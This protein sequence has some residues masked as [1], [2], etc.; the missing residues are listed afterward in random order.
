MSTT[1]AEFNFIKPDAS[2]NISPTPF[3]ENFDKVESLFK[4]IRV[5]YV[6]AQGQQ[7]LWEYRRWSSGNAECW[8]EEYTVSTMYLSNSWGGLYSGSIASPGKYPITFKK[9]PI[10]IPTFSN[11]STGTA[12]Y[13]FPIWAQPDGTTTTCP[14]FQGI[15]PTKGSIKNIKLGVYVKGRWK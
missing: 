2:D 12:D 14:S 3:N 9:S 6:V 5:D 1:T 13:S 11:R 15:D 4:D 10:V 8:I 7:G